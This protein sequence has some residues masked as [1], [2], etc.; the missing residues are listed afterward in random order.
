MFLPDSVLTH[1]LIYGIIQSDLD[2]SRSYDWA[3][4]D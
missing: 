4:D 2:S 3:V 1:I